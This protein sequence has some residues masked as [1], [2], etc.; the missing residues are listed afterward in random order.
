MRLPF[1]LV[2][3]S[4]LGVYT[5]LTQPEWADLIVVAG[6]SAIAS[7]ILLVG[8]IIRP[9]KGGLGPEAKWIVVDGSNVMFWKDETPQIKTVRDVVNHLSDRGFTV[10][11]MFDAN[12]GYRLFGRY[13]HDGYM[14]R[15]LKLPEARV[16]VVPKGEPADPHILSAARD[17]DAQIVTNDRYRDWVSDYPEIAKPGHLIRG[18]Y[19]SDG[20]CLEMWVPNDLQVS[21][22][23][24]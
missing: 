5:A 23:G 21:G 24:A 14:A 6:P 18:D 1:L 17:L 20:L 8:A 16:M 7:I 11:V 12:A 4:F 10:G 9:A 19:R 15:Q 2:L 22:A 3:V 13:R